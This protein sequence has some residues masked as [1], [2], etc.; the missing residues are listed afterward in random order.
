MQKSKRNFHL[1]F[2][3]FV[4]HESNFE[5]TAISAGLSCCP[6]TNMFIVQAQIQF[7]EKQRKKYV[8]TIYGSFHHF[9]CPPPTLKT[10]T[11]KNQNLYRTLRELIKNSNCAVTYTY[12]NIY[13]QP[14][15]VNQIHLSI[16][17]RYNVEIVKIIMMI[18]WTP[19]LCFETEVD[20]SKIQKKIQTC[21]K[22]QSIII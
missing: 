11:K 14:C 7:T 20:N 1:Y 22:F 13:T 21:M 16:K 9:S 4:N 18:I 17:L 2:Q 8:H 5:G 15:R 12:M 19:K 6:I 10:S 3:I